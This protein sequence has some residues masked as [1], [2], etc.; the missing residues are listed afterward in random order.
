[1]KVRKK[2]TGDVYAMKVLHKKPI[3]QE[4]AVQQSKAENKLQVS[5]AG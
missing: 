3:I 1:M 2:D 5:R 4:R